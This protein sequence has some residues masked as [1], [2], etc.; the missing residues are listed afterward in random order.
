MTSN[1][2]IYTY[3]PHK[4]PKKMYSKPKFT[5]LHDFHKLLKD[6]ATNVSTKLTNINYGLLPLIIS[7]MDW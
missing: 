4:N 5:G 7:S 6:N 2:V 3:L 1:M